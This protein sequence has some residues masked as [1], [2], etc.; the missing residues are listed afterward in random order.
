MTPPANDPKTRRLRLERRFR[1]QR[2]FSQ[3]SSPL[4]ACLCGV[5]AEWLDPA[6]GENELCDWLLRV[7]QNCASFAVPMLLSAAIHREILRSNPSFHGL[8][9]YYPTVGGK[10]D[11]DTRAIGAELRRLILAHGEVLGEF[12]QQ[13]AVQTNE[14]ARG[15][16]WVL[17]LSY[18]AWPEIVLADLGCSA[19]LNLVADQRH[20]RLRGARA[21]NGD[22]TV[23]RGRDPQFSV[24][25]SGDF[26]SPDQSGLPGIRARI[27]CD[28]HP[29]SLKN[30][31]DEL[32]LSSFVWGDQPQRL[33]RLQEGIRALHEVRKS[34]AP[35]Q[36]MRADL[37]SHLSS[38][39]NGTVSSHPKLPLVIYNTYLTPYLEDK[40]KSLGQQLG[41]WA[42][43]QDR[44][45][46]WLQWEPLDQVQKPPELGWL[47][48]TIELWHGGVHRRWH[49]AWV[50][51]HGTEVQWLPDLAAWARYCRCIPQAPTAPR[52]R[53]DESGQS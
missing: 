43:A 38:F 47:G 45:I 36:L 14:T 31:E 41:Q 52:P 19:G 27:G 21:D 15:I 30:P 4:G 28:L 37:P 13:A 9:A 40:G 16:C 11:L 50:H 26:V 10:K 7:S 6:S 53:Q 8:A 12:L 25:T 33:L 34:A 39:L 22:F 18:L 29:F 2:T 3:N 5:V 48:W 1:N 51:P 46:L 17:P 49:L 23:G 42:V 32:T 20:Y 44:P 35:V 24:T